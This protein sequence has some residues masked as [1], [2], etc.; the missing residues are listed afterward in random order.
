MRTAERERLAHRYNDILERIEGLD[1]EE[2]YSD[3]SEPSELDECDDEDDIAD[4]IEDMENELDALTS[5][6]E[7]KIEKYKE[8]LEEIGKIRKDYEKLTE[9]CSK[10]KNEW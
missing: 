1:I 3:Y 7:S 10:Y 8:A 2:V 9:L 5:D 4:S 6:I